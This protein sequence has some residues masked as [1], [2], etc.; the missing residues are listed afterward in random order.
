MREVYR[1]IILPQ[2]TTKTS[3]RPPNFTPKTT[4]KTRTKNLQNQY[5][6]H[7]HKDTNR[8]KCKRNES[9]D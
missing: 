2:E 9:K 3:N 8:N 6:E 4:G 5:R 7:N 1:N